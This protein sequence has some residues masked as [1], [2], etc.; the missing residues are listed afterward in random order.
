MA[1]A[2]QDHGPVRAA[3]VQD[4]RFLAFLH[5]QELTGEVRRE[6]A[7]HPF[8]SWLA[9]NLRG[10][11]TGD[12][13]KLLEE[14][15]LRDEAM[16]EELQDN[17]LAADYAA[18]YLTHQ[19]RAA[20]T[21]SVWLDEDGL[22]RQAPM[23]AVRRWYERYGVQAENWRKLP[24]DHLALQIQFLAHLLDPERNFDN[25]LVEAGTFLDRH[26]LLWIDR[27]AAQ[28][29]ARCA[30]PFYAGLALLSVIYLNEMR[31]IITGITG[32]ERRIKDKTSKEDQSPD[33]PPSTFVPGTGPV[34]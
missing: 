4:L 6:L 25:A 34:W 19:Y 32:L 3:F 1:A 13:L 9:L 27:F 22:E 7:A 21:E 15:L 5:G 30:T 20:P 18:I 28:V 2:P 11:N 12:A 24:D 8:G 29:V 26:L 16:S 14:G 17:E 10:R 23:F 33:L 31:A